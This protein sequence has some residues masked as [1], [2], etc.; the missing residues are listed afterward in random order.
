MIGNVYEFG[1][2]HRQYLIFHFES[3][4]SSVMKIANNHMKAKSNTS[5]EDRANDEGSDTQSRFI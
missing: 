4:D 3:N 2:E 5:T 1:S